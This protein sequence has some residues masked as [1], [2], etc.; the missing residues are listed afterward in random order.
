M[1]YSHEELAVYLGLN[2]VTVTKVFPKIVFRVRWR[3]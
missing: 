3:E 2:R 1:P